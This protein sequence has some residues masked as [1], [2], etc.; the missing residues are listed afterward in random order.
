MKMFLYHYRISHLELRLAHLTGNLDRLL[1]VIASVFIW[2]LSSL[3][4]F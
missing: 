3:I 2:L 1:C 4:W